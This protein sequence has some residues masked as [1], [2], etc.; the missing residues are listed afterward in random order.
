MLYGVFVYYGVLVM[1]KGF[2][3]I[4]VVVCIM[5]LVSKENGIELLKEIIILKFESILL[6]LELIF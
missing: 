4:V 3:V 2:L 5:V 6:V 1:I